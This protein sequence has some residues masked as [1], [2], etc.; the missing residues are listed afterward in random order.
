MEKN[1]FNIEHLQFTTQK[2]NVF[3]TSDTHFSHDNIIRYCNRPYKD[4]YHMNEE[5]ISNWNRVVKPNDIVF[6]L[7]DFMFGDVTTFHSIRDRL[8]GKIYLIMGNHDWKILNQHI[9]DDAFEGVYNQLK[10][11]VDGQ[12]IYLNHFP[13]LAFD[14]IYRDKPTWQLFGHV[15]SDK[16]LHDQH[17]PDKDRLGYLL[18]MQYDVGMDN[19]YYTPISFADVKEIINKQIADSK[20]IK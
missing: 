9:I 16:N 13:Y 6:H 11:T 5:I 8:N 1:I 10:I 15:H 20:T 12:T 7:G 3:F 2:N 14:G 18:P 19:N 17:S 4:I